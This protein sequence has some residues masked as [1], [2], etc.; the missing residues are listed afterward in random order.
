[1]RF[2]FFKS[3]QWKVVVIYL[4]LILVAMQVIGAYFIRE[5]ENYYI[6]NFT[7]TLHTQ[8]NLLA[9]NL[10]RYLDVDLENPQED[11]EESRMGDINYLVNNLLAV[12]DTDVQ[13]IDRNGVVLTTT[14]EDK[15]IIGQKNTRE[16]INLALLGTRY[17]DTQIQPQNGH[18]VRVLTIP[19]KSGVRTIGALYM[20]SSMEDMYETMRR[21]NGI[22]LTATVI[23][24]MMTGSL[25][26]LLARTI[27]SPVKEITR[28]AAAMAEGDFNRRVKVYSNDEI[29]QLAEAFNY[30]TKRLHEALAQ[31][32]EEKQKL[33]SILS[34]MSDGVI[35]TDKEGRVILINA[36]AREML[37]V[38]EEEVLG[39]TIYDVLQLPQD[40]D[41]ILILF[42]GM[43]SVLVLPP[44]NE[45]RRIL[46]AT[47]R[48]LKKDE[49][50]SKGIIAVLQDVT[51]QELLEKQR[52]EFV[53]NVSHELRTPLTTLKSY[54]EALEDGA[55]HDE[56]VA[57]RFVHVTLNETDRMIR[58]VNDLLQ[59]SRL[60]SKKS[61]LKKREMEVQVLIHQALER[62]SV[63]FQ[64]KG[65]QVEKN[66]EESLPSVYGDPDSLTQVMDNLLSNAVKYSFPDTR[67]SIR[68]YIRQE[69]AMMAVE[70]LDVGVGIP[71]RDLSQIFER[72]YRV[73]KAR[74]REMGGTGLGL[75]IAREIIRAHKGDIFIESE[76][77]QGT[78]VTF[79]LPL[80]ASSKEGQSILR[81]EDQHVG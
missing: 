16:E 64:Q 28:Q 36:R 17:E 32:E 23:S 42:K 73:D 55:I 48:Q 9:V 79:T 56:E 53:A 46:R 37:S 20:V 31:N 54:L 57:P 7:E 62:F 58:L 75:S 39:T 43:G 1:M 13:V 8:S 38:H 71:K 72:F 45:E 5:V 67:L 76:V 47:F 51:E 15:A 25:G 63:Q 21:I 34:N 22:L 3:V 50:T 33:S 68:A 18:R 40:E 11:Q 81:M 24:L 44:G 77:N 65:L 41:D 30:L 66:L 19:I 69:E 52:K 78:K 49:Q 35:A 6:N 60:D 29:G 10:Q 26:I 70:I 74:S 12:R 80:A 4:L 27:T 61:I 2:K 14:E 59:L